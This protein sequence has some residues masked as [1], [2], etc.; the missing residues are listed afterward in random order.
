M[1]AFIFP[2]EQS[3][4]KSCRNVDSEFIQWINTA[5]QQY[6]PVSIKI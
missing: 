5:L 1:S 6:T 3:H 2:Y 4:G